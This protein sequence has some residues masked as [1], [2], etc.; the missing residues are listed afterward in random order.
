MPCAAAARLSSGTLT[1]APAR[2]RAEERQLPPVAEGLPRHRDRHAAV[3]VVGRAAD[4][5][6]QHAHALLE[7]DEGDAVGL[8]PGEGG[9]GRLGPVL[10]DGGMD[11]G[12]ARWPSATRGPSRWPRSAGRTR[13]GR[14][15]PVAGRAPLHEEPA[16]PGGL[17]EGPAARHRRAARSARAS[18]APRG[19]GAPAAM[20]QRRLGAEHR[21]RHARRGTSPEP[22][23]TA[24]VGAGDLARRRTRRAAGAR[25]R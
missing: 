16:L 2:G 21:R 13:A 8:A 11:R 6:R 25:P 18:R 7:V 5:V 3:D 10:D 12:P 17:P 24:T 15:R 19:L 23:A 14:R 4:H 22:W 1:S 20:S 9:P